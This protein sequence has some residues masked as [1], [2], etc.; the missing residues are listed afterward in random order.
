[1]NTNFP[2]GFPYS[3]PPSRKQNSYEGMG[4]KERAA[5][6]SSDR[7]QAAYN[8]QSN[9]SPQRE[10]LAEYRVRNIG[11][12]APA[13]PP[14]HIYGNGSTTRSNPSKGQWEDWVRQQRG[15]GMQPAQDMAAQQQAMQSRQNSLGGGMGGGMGGGQMPNSPQAMTGQ[16]MGGGLFGGMGGGMGGGS[17]QDRAALSQMAQQQAMGGGMGGRGMQAAQQQAMQPAPMQSRKGGGQDRAAMSQMAQQQQQGRRPG[18][19]GNMQQPPPMQSRKG[20]S[21]NTQQMAQQQ[22]RQAAQQQAM[23]GMQQSTG[24]MDGIG[25]MLQRAQQPRRAPGNMQQA[26]QPAPMQNR[27]GG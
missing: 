8:R 14:A 15:G 24:G 11:Q 27:K 22:Q 21:M 5:R 25:R 4:A 7:A 2:M 16:Q 9:P 1:M 18:M 10:T 20:G 12:Q 23:G 13:T 19:Q 17:V 26:M 3:M 6:Q